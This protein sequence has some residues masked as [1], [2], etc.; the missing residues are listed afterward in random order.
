MARNLWVKFEN[1][2]SS[3]L[4]KAKSEIQYENKLSRLIVKVNFENERSNFEKEVKS[5]MRGQMRK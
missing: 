4:T 1:L 5:E 3:L 2:G